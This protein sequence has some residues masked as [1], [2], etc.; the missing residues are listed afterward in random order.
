MY[1]RSEY[2]SGAGSVVDSNLQVP[3]WAETPE[4]FVKMH[5]EALESDVV[6]SQLHLWIDLTF[7]VC[8]AG[9]AF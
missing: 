2:Q 7:G 6:S 9:R 4:Q 3:D 8:N 5:R 1:Q